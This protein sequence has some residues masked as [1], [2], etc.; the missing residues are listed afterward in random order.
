MSSRG[1]KVFTILW[2][3]D[4]REIAVPVKLCTKADGIYENN[5]GA[6][7]FRAVYKPAQIS[8]E[9]TD[10]EK[11]KEKVKEA[12]DAWVT[13]RWEIYMRVKINGGREGS[14]DQGFKVKIGIDFYAVGTHDDGTIVHQQ[15][16]QPDKLPETP[17]EEVTDFTRWGSHTPDKGMPDSGYNDFKDGH[18]R[19]RDH[20]PETK[21]LV[22][23]TQATYD[24]LMKFYDKLQVLLDNMHGFF[25][26]KTICDTILKLD[27]CGPALLPP[28]PKKKRTR[29]KKK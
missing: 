9:D 3:Q 21:A 17:N 1:K 20:K 23:A 12:L 22:P 2:E 24:A 25:H 19:Y 10:A 16:P 26:P 7:Y 28:P 13:V 14:D 18:W 11:L 15:I 29:R 8:L 6:F 27:K 4:G 5:K